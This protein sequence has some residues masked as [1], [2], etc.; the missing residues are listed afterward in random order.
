MAVLTIS[1]QVGSWGDDIAAMVAEKMDY[2]L[3]SRQGISQLAQECDPE[4]KDACALYEREMAEGFRDRVFYREPSYHSLFESLNYELA[5]QD[6]VVL[7]GRG[8]QIVL[9]DLPGVLKVRIVAPTKIRVAR[10][11]ESKGISA[12][13]AAKFVRH[14]DKQ[15]RA[16]VETMFDKNL[17]D[18][19]LYDLVVNTTAL[20]K[21]LARDLICR[22]LEEIASHPDWEGLK[23]DLARRSFG[24]RVE[25]AIKKE[26]FTTPFHDIQ[27]T[28]DA[29]GNLVLEGQVQDRMAQGQAAKI[30]SAYPG[31]GTVQNNLR[32]TDL[33]F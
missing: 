17:A 21:E 8:A 14:Y 4:F 24:K 22:G 13:E 25:S 1:R 33:V 32:T 26:V 29:G 11:Q 16:M 23:V 30:A 3:I 31:V 19:S 18:W 7:V 15:R 5:A 10:L 9:A 20:S 6:R 27:V 12:E 2:R 28:A